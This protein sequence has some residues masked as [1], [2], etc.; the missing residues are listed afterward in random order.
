MFYRKTIMTLFAVTSV[1]AALLCQIRT[2]DAVIRSIQVNVDGDGEVVREQYEHMINFLRRNGRLSPT[3]GNIPI[4][5]TTVQ[6]IFEIRFQ[7]GYF[8]DNDVYVYIK[9]VNLYVIGFSN[10]INPNFVYYFSDAGN[11]DLLTSQT[12]LDGS[13]LRPGRNLGDSSYSTLDRDMSTRQ[14]FNPTSAVLRKMVAEI[15]GIVGSATGRTVM[16]C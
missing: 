11:S 13:T 15:R 1:L 14:G 10:Q 3:S 16:W 6:D 4:T 7:S 2:A 8:Q 5:T 9:P 12:R